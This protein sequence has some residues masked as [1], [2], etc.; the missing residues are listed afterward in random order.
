MHLARAESRLAP[1]YLKLHFPAY[2][3]LFARRDRRD[4][5]R[6]TSESLLVNDVERSLELD[7]E[8]FVTLVVFDRFEELIP[9]QVDLAAPL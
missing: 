6:Y 3:K 1:A 7:E 4:L 2:L 5:S 9:S 8:I